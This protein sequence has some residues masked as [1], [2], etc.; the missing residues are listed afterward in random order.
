VITR[1]EQTLAIV[2]TYDDDG[3][4]RSTECQL[5]PGITIHSRHHLSWAGGVEIALPTSE[6]PLAEL[7][8]PPSWAAGGRVAL[9]IDADR[10]LLFLPA[11]LPDPV[12]ERERIEA[13]FALGRTLRG[14]QGPYR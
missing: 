4:L 7:I 8:A 3:A 14:E 5:D 11:P 9:Q 1:D 10:V 6:L 12:F 13:L 2:T